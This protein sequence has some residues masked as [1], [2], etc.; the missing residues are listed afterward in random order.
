M[1]APSD[2]G[3]PYE[4]LPLKTPDAVTLRCYLLSLKKSLATSFPDL[5]KPQMIADFE[6]DEEVRVKLAC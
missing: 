1:P 2:Y 5:I 4:E 6:T 3:L